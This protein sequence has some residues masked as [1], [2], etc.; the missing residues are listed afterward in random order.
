M[1]RRGAGEEG[2]FL[3][4]VVLLSLFFAIFIGAERRTAA[5]TARRV[6]ALAALVQRVLSHHV[7]VLVVESVVVLVRVLVVVAAKGEVHGR[8]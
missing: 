3:I 2:V 5:M 4:G 6:A 1:R 8:G 7:S